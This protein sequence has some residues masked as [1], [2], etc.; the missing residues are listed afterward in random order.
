[1]KIKTK[2][3]ILLLLSLII[4]YPTKN[5]FAEDIK[6]D[7]NIEEFELEKISNTDNQ[8]I[9]SIEEK[10]KPDE[11]NN[12]YKEVDLEDDTKNIKNNKEKNINLKSYNIN[13]IG[14]GDKFE[15]NNMNSS[16]FKT[17]EI[18]KEDNKTENVIEDDKKIQSRQFLT[19]EAETGKEFILVVDYYLD[20]K[21]VKF[22]T[23]LNEDDLKNLIEYQNSNSTFK[24]INK[25]EETKE[26]K[27]VA[28]K[29]ETTKTE[30]K[31]ETKKKVQEKKSSNFLM[32]LVMFGAFII[33]GGYFF[34][35]GKNE[36]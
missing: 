8:K 11:I 1:M 24:N 10:G 15:D 32:Y 21:E 29:Q 26:E 36:K 13:S 25:K 18:K 5:I 19:L 22:L 20:K 34:F 6:K 30:S 27:K 14:G 33:A 31:T 3:K 4:F 7:I 35:K 2:F 12:I 16:N 17:T 9:L 23:E 28:I